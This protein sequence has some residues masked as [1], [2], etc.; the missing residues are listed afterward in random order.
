MNINEVHDT[1]PVYCKRCHRKLKN[2]KYKEL[3][4]GKTCYERTF[5]LKYQHLTPLFKAVKEE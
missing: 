5:T 3:G 4:Y 1:E 2:P